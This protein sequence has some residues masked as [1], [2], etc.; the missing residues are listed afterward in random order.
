MNEVETKK[1]EH[2]RYKRYKRYKIYHLIASFSLMIWILFARSF[3]GDHLNTHMDEAVVLVFLLILA[4]LS[5]KLHSL[6]NEFGI[7]DTR[8]EMILAPTN[9][10]FDKTDDVSENIRRYKDAQRKAVE[11]IKLERSKESWFRSLWH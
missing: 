4:L 11:E 8:G 3:L 6:K 5:F 9:V 1:Y 10:S 7:D 2:R